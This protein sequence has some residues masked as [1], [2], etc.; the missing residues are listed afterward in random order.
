MHYRLVKTGVLLWF[1]VLLI[2][3]MQRISAEQ[4]L[5]P[6]YGPGQNAQGT[7]WGIETGFKQIDEDYYV[8]INPM[9]EFPFLWFNVGMQVPLEILAWDI[10]PLSGEK[11][12]SIRPGTYDEWEDYTKLF[13]YVRKGS[14]GYYSPGETNWS[15]FFGKMTDGYIG[16]KTIIYRYVT[17]YDPTVFSPGFMFDINNDWGGVEVFRSNFFEQEVDAGR[18]YVRPVGVYNSVSNALFADA[19]N[20]RRNVRL[21]VRENRDP[22][23]NGGILYL[24][25]PPTLGE[26]TDE[27][28]QPA[29]TENP[30]PE[31]DST[32][33]A[34]SP[35]EMPEYKKVPKQ[36]E[37]GALRQHLHP[38]LRE[39]LTD[40]GITFIEKKDPVT[41]KVKVE[42]VPVE[43][44]PGTDTSDAG[45]GGL[46]VKSDD[47]P[48]DPSEPGFWNR[49]AVGY[50]IATDKNAPLT[51]ETDGSG[52]LVVD[53]EELRPRSLETETLTIIG[54]D[55]EFKLSPLTWLDLTPY[56][57]VN[58]FKHFENS[59]G[60]HA[61]ID[62][63]MRFGS[64]TFTLRPEYREMEENYIPQYFDAYYSI[65]RS[66]YLPP[67]AE[68]GDASQTKLSYFKGLADSD[69]GG[70]TKGFFIH[71]MADFASLFIIEMNYEDY[72]GPDNSQIFV[73]FYTANVGG[74]FLNGYYTKKSFNSFGEAF[75]VNENSL[76]AGELG[77]V[78]FG[79]LYVKAVFQRTWI[80]DDDIGGYRSNDEQSV[81]FGFS[82]NM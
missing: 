36:G 20:L 76:L 31:E 77:Y 58:R 30:V 28:G 43:Q 10:E 48:T 74:F 68:P 62:S 63:A 56:V 52:N 24:E 6:G 27:A 47:L 81:Q 40:T 80:Y 3:P 46:P 15:M 35:D 57:D 13:A 5:P 14:H 21:S 9:F 2:L 72:D 41:G 11:T 23:L 26:V 38:R 60:I 37:G 78:L 70:K 39:Q 25:N 44:T 34:G 45:P 61:G 73:G 65:E 1:T 50:T 79:G 64:V 18:I 33:P 22:E 53:P 59:E 71:G 29:D 17:T 54:I 7:G 82:S 49:W 75:E 66:I 69:D 55:T 12:P 4:Y 16:H 32:T 42:P 19:G 8:T 51:L 67:G